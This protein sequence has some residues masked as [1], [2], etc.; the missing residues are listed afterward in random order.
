MFELFLGYFS[1]EYGSDIF[2]RLSHFHCQNPYYSSEYLVKELQNS[3]AETKLSCANDVE[4]FCSSRDEL[5][6][7]FLSFGNGVFPMLPYLFN[8]PQEQGIARL[9]TT[10]MRSGTT[11]LRLTTYEDSSSLLMMFEIGN[12]RLLALDQE[13]KL[14]EQFH[15]IADYYPHPVFGFGKENDMCLYKILNGENPHG[16]EFAPPLLSQQCKMSAEYMSQ[17]Y[18]KIAVVAENNATVEKYLKW[19]LASF[20]LSSMLLGYL[21]AQISKESN[22]H[23]EEPG[24]NFLS[25]VNIVLLVALTI[26]SVL[27]SP[28]LFFMVMLPAYVL[29]RILCYFSDSCDSNE[30]ESE[31]DDFEYLALNDED[32]SEYAY[33]GVPLRVI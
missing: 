26:S 14:H 2:Q 18:K 29:V 28:T 4:I 17:S 27:F 25:T 7:I 33:V 24:E 11:H 9:S 3:I 10:E 23:V 8:D 21:T 31:E 1:D 16:P 19:L 15:E 5:H 22:Q 13:N 20:V 6:P 12:R 32:E 30:P